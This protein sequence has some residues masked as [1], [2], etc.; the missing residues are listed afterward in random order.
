MPNS[1]LLKN[2]QIINTYLC[3]FSAAFGSIVLLGLI[4]ADT[5][6]EKVKKMKEKEQSD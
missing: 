4:G 6:K 2:V 3:L 5:L 1:E